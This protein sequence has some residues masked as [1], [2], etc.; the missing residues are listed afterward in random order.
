MDELKN[1]S[2]TSVSPEIQFELPYDSP[3]PPNSPNAYSKR[4]SKIS[5][6]ITSISLKKSTTM[7]EE[8]KQELTDIKRTITVMLKNVW[9]VPDL[10]LVLDCSES[11]VR[12]MAAES[13]IPCYKQNG[14]LFFKRSEIENWQ[15]QNR[16]AAQYE[17]EKQAATK[18]A[19]RR[20][21]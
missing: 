4:P 10:A 13:V 9:S 12:H 21:K 6:D 3:Q 16:R 11:R 1:C 2:N 18:L 5:E 17:I 14:S 8:L 15:L 20:I 19:L 7:N